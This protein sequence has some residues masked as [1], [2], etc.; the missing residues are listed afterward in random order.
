MSVD[1]EDNYC[2]LPFSTWN[3]YDD[4]ILETSKIILDLFEKHNI[5]ATFFTVGYIAQKHPQLIE[6]IISK[7]HEIASHGYS[8][9]DISATDRQGFELD[10]I[11]SKQILEKVSGEK[12]LGFRAPYFSIRNQ[13]WAFE[14]LRKHIRYD[15]SIFPV[16]PHYNCADAPR[17]IYTV[18]EK[19][20][21][22]EDPMSNFSEIPMATLSLPVIGAFPIAGGFHLRLLPIQI[23][24]LGIK[25]LNSS[26]HA[27]MIYIHPE[28]LNK[29]RARLPGYGWH[30]F[31]GLKGA[32][33]KF[34]AL[35]RSF[36]FSS[37]REVLNG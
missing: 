13:G 1:L 31:W 20:H 11:K 33:K 17:H 37:A 2:D 24:K 14:F 19:N 6:E 32:K 8:H 18:S 34:E 16:K 26:G 28:D 35:L 3:Q 15:S 12:V 4:R 36:K 23:V 22:E 29:T 7:G 21:F 25:Q 30:Y 5:R 9:M 10:F 27:A